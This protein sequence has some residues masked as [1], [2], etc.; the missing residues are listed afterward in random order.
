[1]PGRAPVVT[2]AIARWTGRA[3]PSRATVLAARSGRA[4]NGPSATSSRTVNR[5]TAG[6]RAALFPPR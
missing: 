4:V 2:T 3:S 1:M 5:V 6:L